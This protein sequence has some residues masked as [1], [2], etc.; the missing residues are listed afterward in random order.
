MASVLA[1][2]IN[3][4]LKI[5]NLPIRVRELSSKRSGPSED[6]RARALKLDHCVVIVESA[7][8]EVR[9]EFDPERLLGK[10]FAP[11]RVEQLW[12]QRQEGLEAFLR[13]I[14]AN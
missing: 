5:H 4:R 14:S 9:N 11:Q 6:G 7:N 3:P 13:L 12:M 8:D 2:L 10:D 1:M